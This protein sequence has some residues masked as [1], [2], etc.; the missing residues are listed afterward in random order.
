MLHDLTHAARNLCRTPSFTAAAVATLALGIGASTA[1]FSVARAVL[2]REVPVDAPAELYFVSHGIGKNASTSSTYPLYDRL[3]RRTDVFAGATAYSGRTF[4]VQTGGSLEL[5][6]GQFVSGN[7]HAVL[8]VPFVLGRGFSGEDDRVPGG[9]PI[10]VI[11]AGYWARRFGGRPDVIGTRLDVGGH[12]ATIVGVTAPGFEGLD[13]GRPRD[14]TLPFSMRVLE[15]PGLITSMTNWIGMPLVVRIRPD[16]SEPQ[17]SAALDLEIA[18]YLT[19][20]DNRDL[21]PEALGAFSLVPASHGSHVLRERY[22][23]SLALLAGMVGLVL[24]VACVNVA[25]LLMVRGTARSREVAVRLS[26]GGS[27]ARVV[28]QLLV[29]SVLL[30]LCG[31]LAGVFLAAWGTSVVA[32]LLRIGRNPTLLDLAPDRTVLAFTVLVS[33]AIGLAAGLVPAMRVTRRAPGPALRGAVSTPGKPSGRRALVAAQLAVCLALISGAGLLVRTLQNIH[34]VDGGFHTE[35]VLLFS[36]DGIG[37]PGAVGRVAP[38]CVEVVRRLIGRG[39]L[40]GACATATPSDT[41]FDMFRVSVPGFTPVPD[42]GDHAVM[43][44]AVSPSYFRTLGVPL[45]AGRSF[46]EADAA[47]S[48]A[49]AIVSE[50]MARHFFGEP[51]PLGRSFAL[52]NRTV[53][54]V[55]VAADLRAQL[56]DAPVRMA[57]VPLAQQLA[58][59][60]VITGAL[61]TSIDPSTLASDVRREVTALDREIA[62]DYIRTMQA[63]IDATLVRERLLAALAAAFGALALI[64]SCIGLYGVVSY[65]VDRRTREIGIRAAVGATRRNIL[66]SVLGATLAVAAA[67]I[68]IGLAVIAIAAPAVMNT[69]GEDFLFGTT[70]RD[71]RI[72][73]PSTLI[74]AATAVAAGYLPARRAAAL[75]PAVA[76]RVE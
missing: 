63:Q 13:P 26:L 10:A 67:G 21:V 54:I 59:N 17:A 69:L 5:V 28:R 40:S 45:L 44:N 9:S 12:A 2:L 52:A 76:L 75:D 11:S 51:A 39:V 43:T 42:T 41:S 16:V 71:V 58:R 7:Y 72:L 73:I 49:V 47:G 56:R 34:R 36:L 24:L 6:Q 55:G 61:H 25:N 48:V 33:V 4:K 62:V 15:E 23:R 8:G 38:L 20:P 65:D 35:R 18:R 30:A 74:L 3:R 66:R 60:P 53:T 46:A 32:T 27:R 64:L 57:Y 37:S 68:A 31:G 14:L 19:E 22:G 70:P 29:E 50:S 1:V